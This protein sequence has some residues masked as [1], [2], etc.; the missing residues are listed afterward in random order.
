MTGHHALLHP[1][2]SV[3]SL[4][5]LIRDSLERQFP[6]VWVEA[7]ISNL[8]VPSSGHVYFTL[9]DD[10]SQLRGVLFRTTAQ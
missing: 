7:E 8:R 1:I 4:T 5:R 3:S 9:K 2:L 6:D 10:Q